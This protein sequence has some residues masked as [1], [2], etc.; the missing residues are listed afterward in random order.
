MER[1]GLGRKERKVGNEGGVG[2]WVG[3]VRGSR[4]WARVG[5][6]GVGP[7]CQWGGASRGVC[8]SCVLGRCGWVLAVG[9]GEGVG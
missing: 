5:P 3:S 9:C 8:V 6:R 1:W 4:V 2:G 7:G